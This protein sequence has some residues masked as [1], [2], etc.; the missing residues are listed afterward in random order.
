MVEMT[1]GAKRVKLPGMNNGSRPIAAKKR[2]IIVVGA[3][4]FIGTSINR[5]FLESGWTVHSTV[6]TRSPKDGELRLDVTV[7]EDFNQL[8]SAI[9]IINAA[10]LPDQAA[11]ASLMRKVHVGGMRNLVAWARRA[12]CPHIVHLSSISVYG[13]ATV[14][15]GRTESATRRRG[16]NPLL[17]SLPYGRTKARAE[18]ILERSGLQWSAP[19]L[20]AVYGP[21]DSFFTGQMKCLLEDK[22]RPMPPG[23]EKIV[24][25]FPVDR[26]G[27]L[28]ETILKHEPLNSA[29]NASGAGVPW[30]EI[31]KAYAEVWKIPVSYDTR[32]KLRDFLNFSEPGHQMAAYYA[33]FGAEFP[34]DNLRESLD[35][36]PGGDWRETVRRAAEAI[37]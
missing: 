37:S 34:D 24:S 6:F 32:T 27:P 2:A 10:G 14:G 20:P 33:T 22:D 36:H 30:K 35:W 8:P 25:I 15:T 1:S 13:N 26:I 19:R 21:G 11:S 5:H 17:A 3:D 4:G 7:P 29:M 9:P 16:W 31:V 23:G 28:M 12:A 18:A